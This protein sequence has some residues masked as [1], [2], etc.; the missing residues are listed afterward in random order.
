MLKPKI[1]FLLVTALM[2]AVPATAQRAL[3][4]T[5]NVSRITAGHYVADPNHTQIAWSVSHL[6]FNVFNGIFGNA[7]GTLA[8]DPAKPGASVLAIDVPLTKVVTTRDAL[9]AHLQT[10][11][12]F[13]TAKFPVA[14]FR[15]TSVTVTGTTAKIA[16]N[17]TIRGITKPII[18][19]AHFVGAGINPRSKKETVGFEATGRVTRT[20]FGILYG[21]GEVGEQVDLRITAG[22]EKAPA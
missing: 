22:F 14:T 4:G 2:I 11:D 15:S 16:G 7:T 6:G 21:L 3:P 18:L 20:D 17:L 5:A 1:G 10:S 9:T 12:F 8:L 13:D 19:D